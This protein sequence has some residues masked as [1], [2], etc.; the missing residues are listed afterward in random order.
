MPLAQIATAMPR[1]RANQSDVSAM[2]GANVAELPSSP[3]ST[4]CARRTPRRCR[5]QAGATKPTAEPGGADQE[6]HHD[7]A[8]VGEPAHQHAAEAEA[9][10]QQRVR[11]RRL[12]ARDAELRLHAGSTTA[13][14]YIPPL[15]I[16]ISSEDD[17]EARP[18]VARFDGGIGH[19]N[20]VILNEVKDLIPRRDPSL[21]SG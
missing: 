19:V 2:S 8:A 6:R 17:D 20:P 4:P 13:T 16:V 9:D 15:P 18:R 5:R 21:R 12:G 3:I 11:Q 7:A 1:R 10:H 14:M